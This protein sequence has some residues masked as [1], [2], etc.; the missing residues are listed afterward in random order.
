MKQGRWGGGERSRIDG[1]GRI[2]FF[3]GAERRD[4]GK[5]DIVITTETLHAQWRVHGLKCCRR[6]TARM[7]VETTL[8]ALGSEWRLVADMS[9]CPFPLLFAKLPISL[10]PL[11]LVL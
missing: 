5:A 2:K 1:E 10:V 9:E 4:N 7:G 8:C 11:H 3:R 6:Q